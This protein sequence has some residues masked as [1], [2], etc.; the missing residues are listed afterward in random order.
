MVILHF[1]SKTEG[2]STLASLSVSDGS[3]VEKKD[4]I[5]KRFR[6]Y[7]GKEYEVV[8][9]CFDS[10]DCWK[11]VVYRALYD[12]VEFGRNAVWVRDWDEFFGE[13]EVGGEVVKR[14][15]EL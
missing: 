7:K 3:L 12:D 13:V 9:V 11:R 15:A 8:G 5:G 2:S 10:D 4:F 14:F 6:H 1:P